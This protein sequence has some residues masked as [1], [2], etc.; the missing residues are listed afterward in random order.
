MAHKINIGIAGYGLMGRV[1][2]SCYSNL[3]FCYNDSTPSDL[4]SVY[5]SKISNIPTCFNTIYGDYDEFISDEFLSL[6][7]ICSPNHVHHSQVSKAITNGKHIYCEKPLCSVLSD[8]LDLVNKISETRLINQTALVYRFVPAIAH[9]RDLVQ[10]NK[11]GKVL[12]FTMKIRHDSYLFKNKHEEWRVNKQCSG[13][14]TV[15]D[16][17]IHAF[18]AIRF[19]LGNIKSCNAFSLTINDTKNDFILNSN[20]YA[21]DMIISTCILQNNAIGTIE[22]SK[23]SFSDQP[24]WEIE[25]FGSLGSLVTNSDQFQTVTW[26]STIDKCTTE[27]HGFGTSEYSLHLQKWFPKLPLSKDIAPHMASIC[28]VLWAIQNNKVIDGVPT[29]LEAYRSQVIVEAC[30]TSLQNNNEMIDINYDK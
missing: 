19:M 23:L 11:I 12:H 4:Y 8:S 21:D 18:D 24:E 30:L 20:E 26:S 2:S 1:H 5:T 27:L 28:S 29:F 14:G 10:Q 9:I 25:V 15:I 3:E 16:L 7:D 22:C 6:V 17:G 13:G